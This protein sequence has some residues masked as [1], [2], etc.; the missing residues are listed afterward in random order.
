M[1]E[2]RLLSN[3]AKDDVMINAYKNDRDLYATIASSVYHNN[4]EDNLEHNPDGTIFEEGKKR[5]S[6][7]KSL[8]LGILYGMGVK[9]IAAKIDSTKE[10]AQNILDGFFTSYK[11]VKSWIDETENKG[12]TLG[13]VEDWYGRRRRLPD[14]ML[15]D[16]EVKYSTESEQLSHTFNP[17]LEC[18]DIHKDLMIEKYTKLLPSIKTYKDY[19][20]LNA[21]A[22]KDGVQIVSNK[23]K[24]AADKRKCVNA[25][26]QGGAATMTKKAMVD[27]YNDDEM[28]RLGYKLLLTVHDEVIGECP[29]RNAEKV[30]ERL[31]YLMR[32]CI[33][34]YCDTPFKCDCDIADHWY[35]TEYES[36]L[37]KEFKDLKKKKSDQE[38]LEE[39]YELHEESTKEQINK[40]L[41]GEN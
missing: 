38:S 6:S 15:P 20:K 26:V 32:N 13:Y 37:Q 7:V 3:Y 10:E 18:E 14:L 12:Q 29:L 40:I 17:F 30:A 5:R 24:K 8:L 25:V 1:T 23:S 21:Q 31:S 16:Y 28:R 19:D 34:D 39:M 4:Y 33:K 27:I 41:L 11:T 35:E 22:K 2:P 9:S 36:S